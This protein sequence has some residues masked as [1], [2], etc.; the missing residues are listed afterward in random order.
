[1]TAPME[2]GYQLLSKLFQAWERN[3]NSAK[4]KSLPISRERAAVYFEVISPDDKDRMH[5]CLVNAEKEGCVELV[6]GKFD[7]KHL[8]KKIW[9]VDGPALGAFLGVPLARDVATEAK[10]RFADHVLLDDE[11]AGSLV[12]LFFEGWSINKSVNGISPGDIQS[13]SSLIK[14]L[15]AV[16]EGLHIGMDMRTFSAKTLGDSKFMERIQSRFTRAWNDKYQTGLDGPELYESLGLI[17]FPPSVHFKGPLRIKVQGAWV[18][19]GECGTYL[20]FPPDLIESIDLTDRP[21]Y[22]L[23]VEN[24]ASFSRHCRSIEDQGI[25]VYSAGFLGP[26][27]TPLVSLF[28]QMVDRDIPFFHW[29]DID[30]GG[31]NIAKHVQKTISRPL[32]LHMMSGGL[33][34]AHGCFPDRSQTKKPTPMEDGSPLAELILDFLSNDPLLILEQENIDPGSPLIPGGP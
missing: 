23:T 28:D 10:S 13:A 16:R 11:W 33:L 3:P 12:G 25:I 21:S 5:A 6:W 26:S 30:I 14:A 17:K 29:G 15:L 18:P 9:L 31:L 34:K 8:L 32:Q 1:M 24:F 4:R 27:M 19:L 2:P 22:F 7:E 20:G